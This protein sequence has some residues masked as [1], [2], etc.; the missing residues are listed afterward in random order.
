LNAHRDYFDRIAA[1]WDERP[2]AEPAVVR[3][4]VAR[5]DLDAGQRVLDVGAGTGILLPHLLEAVGPGGRV[6]ALDLSPEMLR[7]ARDKFSQTNL[8]FVCAP[9][10]ELPLPDEEFDRVICFSVFPHFRDQGRAVR[11]LA[12]VLRP[13]GRLIVAHADGR[14]ELNSFHRGLDAPVS[15]DE[16]PEAA[17]MQRLL[18]DAGLR[19]IDLEDRPGRYLLRAVKQGTPP[20]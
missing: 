16:L 15:G 5:F 7:R 4:I 2:I 19:L 6:C 3:R 12:R 8:E 17:V 20:A 11:E 18:R 1:G 14:E 13:A 10:E 9:A